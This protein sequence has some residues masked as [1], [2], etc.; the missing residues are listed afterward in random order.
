MAVAAPLVMSLL[1]KRVRDE[2]M[3][4]DGFAGRL[5]AESGAIRNAL[6]GSL[7]DLFW[8]PASMAGAAAPVVA[9]EV[10]KVRSTNWVPALAIALGLGALWFMLHS[11]RPVIETTT[12][13]S[14][15]SASRITTPVGCTL[16]TNFNLP[17]GG[18][19]SHLLSFLQN[20]DPKQALTTSFTFDRLAFEAGSARLRPE[21]QAQL[22]D[23]A[24]ILKYCPSIHM[25]IKGYTD[26]VGS[27]ETNLRL[28][29]DRATAV[30]SQL[31]VKGVSP[32]RLAAAGY[33][34]ESPI[35]DNAT[36]EGRAQ[37]RR[38][39]MLITQR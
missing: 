37:N 3:T 21:S 15:G 20:F 28:S 22:N 5:Q 18:V 14:T 36:A 39:S 25:E 26:S 17:E 7:R 16:P 32:E 6:P 12:S 4:M 35:A 30:M 1:G 19:E 27:P 8:P 31:I 34:Q 23:M 24:A 9:Q 13:L 2:G 33:G 29:R 10:H 11:R 38:V